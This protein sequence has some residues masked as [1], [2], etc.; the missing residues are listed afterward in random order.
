MYYRKQTEEQNIVV[1]TQEIDDEQ[2]YY[3]IKVNHRV[4]R[5]IISVDTYDDDTMCRL[6]LLIPTLPELPDTDWIT[7]HISRDS[8][9]GQLISTV[10]NDPLPAVQCLWH[11][12][13][14]DVLT[15]QRVKYLKT[16]VDEVLFQGRPAIAKIARW[17]WEIPR[18]ENE[19]RA[20]SI[21]ARH[22][23]QCAEEEPPVAPSFLGH[24]TENGHVMGILLEKLEG[25]FASVED[26]GSCK[27]V[28]RKLY[29]MGLIHGDVNRYNFIVYEVTGL[30]R[31]IDFEHVEDFEEETMR[32]ELRALED[33]LV[34][35]SGRGGP[36]RV[37]DNLE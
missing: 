27:E 23:Q 9:N 5:L 33:E 24:L 2:G 16:N 29:G 12:D 11:P 3:R 32:V 30:V 4:R 8:T 13:K 26:L 35:T 10:S 19:T 20:Y 25:R 15:L 22:Q 36:A 14:H 1:L 21:I 37:V 17:P 31:M 6:Y 34:E 18:L 28:V 7:M